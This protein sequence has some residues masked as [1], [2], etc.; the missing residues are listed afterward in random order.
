LDLDPRLGRRRFTAT[1]TPVGSGFRGSYNAFSVGQ[2]PRARRTTVP[3]PILAVLLLLA[4]SC[5]AL[6]TED[7]TAEAPAATDTTAAQIVEGIGW[8][9]ARLGASKEEVIKSLGQPDADSTP[10]RLTWNNQRV[11]CL[12]RQDAP[13]IIEIHFNRGFQ[14][15]LANGLKLGSP[16]TQIVKLYGQPDRL[17]HRNGANRYDYSRKGILFWTDDG[18]IAQIVIFKPRAAVP[19][20]NPNSAAGN[21]ADAQW[22][23]VERIGNGFVAADSPMPKKMPDPKMDLSEAERLENFDILWQAIDKHYSFF[24][25]KRIDWQDVKRRYE[26]RVKTAVGDEYYRALFEL[27]SVLKDSHAYMPNYRPR[28]PNFSPNVC[29]RQIEGKP[30]VTL[31]VEGSEA[32]A[33]GLRPGAVVTRV[34]GLSV[35]ERI[36]QLRPLLHTCSSERAFQEMAH[37][38]LLD[39]E[40]N[41]QVKLTFLAPGNE[42]AVEAQLQR[43]ATMP[44]GETWQCRNLPFTVEKSK[45]IWSGT[46]PAGFG[47]IRIL[48]FSGRH[49][50]ADQFD[51]ALEQL[52]DT[53]ALVIDIRDNGGGSGMPQIRMVGR[54]L[55]SRVLAEIGYHKNGPGHQ[56]F[57][58]DEFYISPSGDWQYTK[59]IALLTNMITGSASDLFTCRMRAVPQCITVGTTT[60][61][62]LS[63][64]S[65][66]AVLP[67]GLVV[68]I[69]NGYITDADGRIIELNGNEP[70]IH[71]EP[72]LSDV[73]NGT[74]SVLARAVEAIRA[75]VAS[76]E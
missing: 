55:T 57:A 9:G 39:G 49:E 59:P 37:W 5:T 46:H 28:R 72:T 52:K 67:C 11:D 27:V 41:S 15:A 48:S 43:T 71:V 74:D 23:V 44:Q 66:Y 62:D 25:L 63:G 47:Y 40:Q 76:A 7:K 54:L 12:L 53:P 60:E 14:G 65:V 20:A 51:R 61:G 33:Q 32:F 19:P 56:A 22:R 6:A 34:D 58:K 21:D 17:D 36:E 16:D 69:P 29:L 73:V 35:P 70:R 64:H 42:T 3:R 10:D 24:D 26:P 68:R 2:H 38:C 13:I 18:Q 4:A 1:A 50:I 30:V 75:A 45:F 8:K 31:V